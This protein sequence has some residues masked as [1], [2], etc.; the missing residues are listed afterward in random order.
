MEKPDDYGGGNASN[1]YCKHCTDAQGN[2]LPRETV[3]Q[4]MISFYNRTMG[5]TP[6]QAAAEVDKIMAKMPAWQGQVQPASPSV[7]LD[8]PASE[9]TTVEPPAPETPVEI[10]SSEPDKPVLPEQP[11][12]PVEPV[13]ESVA[14]PVET[15]ET[16]TEQG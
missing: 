10:P 3:R 14:V 8:Q 13:A 7:P 15:E 12:K 9:P 6:E 5:Q 1:P 2:L 11:V 4:N 16:P